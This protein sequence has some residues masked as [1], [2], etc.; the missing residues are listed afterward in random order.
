MPP[1]G[2]VGESW[3]GIGPP[4]DVAQGGYVDSS[5][6]ARLSRGSAGLSLD[7]TN[8]ADVRGNAFPTAIR[9]GLTSATRS[10]P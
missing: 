10:R 3:L 1:R 8:I 5:I 9:S 6:G 4:L 2:L 7:L